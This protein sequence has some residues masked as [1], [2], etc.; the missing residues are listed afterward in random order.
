MCFGYTNEIPK[1]VEE[2]DL[3]TKDASFTKRFERPKS[4]KNRNCIHSLVKK[5]VEENLLLKK[6]LKN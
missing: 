1:T 3:M 6:F 5:K 4:R 2:L